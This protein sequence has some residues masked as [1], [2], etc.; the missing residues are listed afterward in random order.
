MPFPPTPI[1]HSTKPGRHAPLPRPLQP[2]RA[3]PRRQILTLA[4]I[5]DLEM[6]APV[7]DALDALAGDADAAADG[8]VAQFEQVQADTAEAGV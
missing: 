4:N 6:A 2:A 1:R 5:K 7:D 8:E 3:Q